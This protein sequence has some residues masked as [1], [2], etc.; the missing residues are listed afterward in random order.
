MTDTTWRPGDRV[1]MVQTDDSVGTVDG[2]TKIG[3]GADGTDRVP[4]RWDRT[5]IVTE[6]NPGFLRPERSPATADPDEVT[7]GNA[8]RRRGRVYIDGNGVAVVVRDGFYPSRIPP[9]AIVP[10]M[11]STAGHSRRQGPPGRPG[12]SPAGNSGRQSQNLC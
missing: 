1:R 11:E 5:G 8:T 7:I 6:Y 4:V 10:P 3:A 9:A 12:K 2:P